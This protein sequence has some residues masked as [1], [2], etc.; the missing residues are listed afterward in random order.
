MINNSAIRLQMK[1]CRTSYVTFIIICGIPLFL[2]YL[3]AYKYND[4]SAWKIVLLW[5]LAMILFVIW[6]SFFKVIV[7]EE[8]IYYRTLFGGTKYIRFDEIQRVQILFGWFKYSDRFKPMHRIAIEPNDTKKRVIYINMKVF[9]K[10]NL[11]NLFDIM[12]QKLGEKCKF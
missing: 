7:T 8:G 11:N 9:S 10:I 2:G 3:V 1:A 6:L 4:L 12:E 5:L